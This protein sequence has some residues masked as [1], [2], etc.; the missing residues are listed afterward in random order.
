M[1]SHSGRIG[2]FPNLREAF[3][4][5]PCLERDGSD[6]W[7]PVHSSPS[8]CI[9][10]PNDE[11]TTQSGRP[12]SSTLERPQCSSRTVCGSRSASARWSVGR[13]VVRNRDRPKRPTRPAFGVTDDEHAPRRRRPR[14]IRLWSFPH[15][16]SM[17][18]RTAWPRERCRPSRR[19]TRARRSHFVIGKPGA[20]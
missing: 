1:R 13:C 20:Q 10:V 17:Q 11:F 12:I 8:S 3:V 7:A 18:R 9:H 6:T 2:A 14:L 5:C 4:L 19:R 15:H 16:L